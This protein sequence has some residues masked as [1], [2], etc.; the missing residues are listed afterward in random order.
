MLDL[1][2]ENGSM[3]N[4]NMPIESAY[5][6]YYFMAIVMFVQSVTMYEIS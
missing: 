5:G 6:T 1:D 4:V 2:L 3:L